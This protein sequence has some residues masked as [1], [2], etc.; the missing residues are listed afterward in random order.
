VRGAHASAAEASALIEAQHAAG[1]PPV[2]LLWTGGWDST[3][4]LLRLLKVERRAVQPHY[5]ADPGR[6]GSEAERAAMQ[7]IRE[8]LIAGDPRTHDL[9]AP[10]REVGVAAVP[11]DAAISQAFAAVRGRCFI[12]TQYDW[13]ARHCAAQGIDGMQ[14]CI[15]RDDRAHAAIESMVVPCAPE[16]PDGWRIDPARAGSPESTLFR[17]LRFP[18]LQWTKLEMAQESK[19]QGW[20]DV[21]EMTWFCHRPR[22]GMVPCGV[23]AACRYTLQE[24][25]GWRI[26]W[27]RRVLGRIRIAL[28][29]R[30]SASPHA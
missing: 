1:A 17:R 18:L 11:P 10:V 15:H 3:F 24:G 20:H 22:R 21:M 4:Q 29:D 8:R 6:R 30:R 23:C 25:L 2:H 7:R 12:G 9:L 13:L 27:S 19:A 26:P 5:L 28:R 16:S 14:L